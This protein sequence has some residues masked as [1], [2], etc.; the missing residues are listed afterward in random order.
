[1]KTTDQRQDCR[2]PWSTIRKAVSERLGPQELTV[3]TPLCKSSAEGRG[4]TYSELCDIT[5]LGE[6][7][8][9]KAIRS[10]RRIGITIA[11]M[12]PGGLAIRPDLALAQY[13]SLRHRAIDLMVTARLMLKLANEFEEGVQSIPTQP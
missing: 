1:M 7:G 3:C 6:S 9:R 2:H 10:M 8:V 13:R 12:P 11:Y 4:L 5:G